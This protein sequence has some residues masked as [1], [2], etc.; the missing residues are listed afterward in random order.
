MD[1]TSLLTPERI[2]CDHEA[3]SK[4]RAFETLAKLLALPEEQLDAVEIFDALINREKLG[5]TALGNSIAI[6]HA[7]LNIPTPRAALLTLE[8]SIELDAPDKKPVSIL[9][10][11]LLPQNSTAEETE[12]LNKLILNFANKNFVQDICRFKNPQQIIDFFSENL[13]PILAAA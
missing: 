1:I 6:P 4:K 3:S 9:I 13:S 5:C 8:E 2:A 10:A 7:S 11:L 12:I